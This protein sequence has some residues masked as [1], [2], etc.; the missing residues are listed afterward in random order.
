M[1]RLFFFLTLLVAFT[2][3]SQI[4]TTTLENNTE[5]VLMI[6]EL[7]KDSAVWTI[8][9][10]IVHWEYYDEHKNLLLNEEYTILQTA[11]DINTDSK[12][13]IVKDN[14]NSIFKIQLWDLDD[15]TKCITHGFAKTY[16]NYFGNVNY[17]VS[18]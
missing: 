5:R 15:G 16:V 2:S 6:Q 17:V 10:N 12:Y 8:N 9:K 4:T 11:T 14:T 1:K 3:T 7:P 13:Y 18:I